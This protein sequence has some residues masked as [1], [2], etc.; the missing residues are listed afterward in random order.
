MNFNKL[1][2]HFE[3]NNKKYRI[4]VTSHFSSNRT[5]GEIKNRGN[6]LFHNINQFVNIS[7]YLLINTEIVLDKNKNKSA[8]I[9]YKNNEKYG[10]LLKLETNPKNENITNIYFITLIKE[11]SRH[12]N[13]TDMFW[14][15]NFKYYLMEYELPYNSFNNKIEKVKND[16]IISKKNITFTLY[17]TKNSYEND[18]EFLNKY[19]HYLFKS[20]IIEV[21]NKQTK[22]L[23][24]W[25]FEYNFNL[26]I[27]N[28]SKFYL[29]KCKVGNDNKISG[30][31]TQSCGILILKI[32]EININTKLDP[33]NTFIIEEESLLKKEITNEKR[34]VVKIEDN[35]ENINL[36]KFFIN[37]TFEERIKLVI[38]KFNI[39]DSFKE[40]ITSTKDIVEEK[41]CN[42]LYKTIKGLEEIADMFILIKL[43]KTK[44]ELSIF[45]NFTYMLQLLNIPEKTKLDYLKMFLKYELVDD[46]HID[47]IKD[48]IKSSKS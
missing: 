20:K 17:L 44:K 39:E 29:L 7:K 45:K 9:F 37:L 31:L 11:E 8:V 28:K 32:K 22:E 33:N 13:T 26:I 47:K 2:A 30:F 24:E 25:D 35:I 15:E 43:F 36:L 10:L 18:F 21:L 14:K 23:T 38:S 12:F 48:L 42:S 41:K 27:K 40:V 19:N 6:L 5:K 34:N 46:K 4:K 3:L 16:M 1:N